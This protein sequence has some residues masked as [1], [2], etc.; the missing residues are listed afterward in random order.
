MRMGCWSLGKPSKNKSR[1]T[2]STNGP[3]SARRIAEKNGNQKSSE[4]RCLRTWEEMDRGSDGASW[5][6]RQRK[7]LNHG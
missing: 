3:R 4:R 6:R 2:N 7:E 5:D 1:P